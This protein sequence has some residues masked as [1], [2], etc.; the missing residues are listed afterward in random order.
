MVSEVSAR[1]RA[2]A[3]A[4]IGEPD[5]RGR[6]M[7]RIYLV[8]VER[9]GETVEVAHVDEDPY[10][11]VLP[12]QFEAT[13]DELGR[14]R[15]ERCAGQ[16]PDSPNMWFVVVDDSRHTGRDTR[17]LVGF[18]TDYFPD[19]TII[20]E[21][22]FVLLP[23]SNEQQVAAIQWVRDGGV[24]EQIYVEPSLRRSDI[25]RRMAQTAGVYHRMCGWPGVVHASG[26]RTALG[27]A[28]VR[29]GIAEVRVLPH[30][31]LSPPMDPPADD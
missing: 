19:G 9:D 13:V 31:E 6:R 12:K 17:S 7:C 10:A 18:A 3:C 30:S 26:R 28:L 27:E 2:F 22:E 20:D 21:M 29:G 5:Q 4:L 15:M 23:V 16:A 8:P 14:A 11:G 24:V 25:G 1:E